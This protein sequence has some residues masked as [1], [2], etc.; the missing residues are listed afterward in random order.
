MRSETAPALYWSL[1]LVLLLADFLA[2]TLTGERFFD[3]LL[4]TRLQIKGVTL[5]LLDDVFRLHFTFKATEGIFKGLTFLNSN[6]CQERYTSKHSQQ[7][8][9]YR[10]PYFGWF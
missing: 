8:M 5:D 4:F 6:L 1:K 2:I 10:I 3:A 9:V 7:G